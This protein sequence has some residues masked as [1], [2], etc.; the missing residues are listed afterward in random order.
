MKN[1]IIATESS[2]KKSVFER[3]QVD[4]LSVSPDIDESR[5]IDETPKQ[6]VYRL[7]IEKAK[8][9]AKTHNGIIISSDQVA[10]L[11][12]GDNI[13]DEIL[14]KPHTRENAIKHLQK[15][16]GN[17]VIFLTGLA[18]FNSQTQNL[19]THIEEFRVIFRKLS[20]AEIINYVDKEDVLNCAGAFK[21]EGLGIA[22]FASMQGEDH[23]SLIGLPIIKLINMLANEDIHIL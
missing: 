8:K 1:L 5:K 14:T 15:S 9:V 6:M 10:T 11:K 20:D 21:S 22:L 4:F 13:K 16:S 2:F 3:L 23:N 19:Q 12:S 7:A 17:T 18:V